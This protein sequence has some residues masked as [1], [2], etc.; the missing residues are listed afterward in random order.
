MPSVY[1][2]SVLRAV[3]TDPSGICV[4][5]SDAGSIII[6]SIDG[7]YED[8]TS[9]FSFNRGSYTTGSLE[10]TLPELLPGQHEVKVVA[11]D[12]MKN[13]GEGVLAF[14]VL[15]GE[16]PILHE[17]GVYP[18]PS[19]GTR[20][21]FFTTSSPGTYMFPSIPLPPAGMAGNHRGLL[22]SGPASLERSRRRR[23]SPGLGYLHLC[24]G[25]HR[26]IRF[27]V[28][29]RH[30]GGES[31]MQ[32]AMELIRDSHRPVVFTGAGMS[33]ESGMRTF[34]GEDGLWREYSRKSF[35]PSRGFWRIPVLS[36]SGT[37]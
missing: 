36:G 34:R 9:L 8:V 11:R 25:I 1:Q 22:R 27:R 10:Y 12:G 28:G 7:E 23:R 4:L 31:M 13:T 3:L 32:R 24:T 14:N 17:T 21:F 15:Q 30:P 37:E 5:G 29:N 18:N 19:R 6:C 33:S 16:P 26:C 20:A 35:H 2:N